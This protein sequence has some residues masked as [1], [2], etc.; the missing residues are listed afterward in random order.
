MEQKPPVTKTLVWVYGMVI[1]FVTAYLIG[2]ILLDKASQ[3]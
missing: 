1:T 2:G 3:K